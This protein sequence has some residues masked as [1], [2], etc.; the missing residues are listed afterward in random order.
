MMYD[1]SVK[2]YQNRTWSYLMYPLKRIRE[3]K[4]QNIPCWLQ[5]CSASNRLLLR[6][7]PLILS[8]IFLLQQDLHLL[9]NVM[10]V[11]QQVTVL[12]LHA[13]F[14]WALLLC[15]L[16]LLLLYSQQLQRSLFLLG[17]LLMRNEKQRYRFCLLKKKKKKI[18]DLSHIHFL[19][20]PI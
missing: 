12:R 6:L 4:I 18:V 17:Q 8:L 14:F 7:H 1:S 2:E 19:K 10:Q 11:L 13:A 3:I 20:S 9:L 5:Q 16:L 15:L